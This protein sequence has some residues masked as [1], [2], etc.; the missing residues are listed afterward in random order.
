MPVLVVPGWNGSGP[1]HWQTLWEARF[2]GLRRI[3]QRDW[4]RPVRQEWIASIE[5][6]VRET[7]SP[8]EI[9]A[10]SLGCLAVAHWA[11]VHDTSTIRAALLVAPPWLPANG[12]CPP[13]LTSF[14]P[15]PLGPLPFRSVLVASRNDPY[16]SIDRARTLARHWASEFVDVGLQGHINVAS[17]HGPWPAGEELFLRL[18]PENQ[19]F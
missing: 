15:M 16:I 1:E 9:V 7:A 13:E 4:E 3:E 19:T 8:V 18:F 2:A 12:A 14:R 6:A 11:A 10:H 5:A 17:G